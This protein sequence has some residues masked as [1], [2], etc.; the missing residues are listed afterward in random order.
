M[1]SSPEVTR[2]RRVARYLIGLAAI[3]TAV[4]TLLGLLAGVVPYLELINH[5]RWLLLAVSSLVVAAAW[6]AGGRALLRISASVLIANLVLASLPLMAQASSAARPTLRVTTFNLWI[7]N[8]EPQAV[9]GFLRETD[10]DVVVLQEI[11]NRLEQEIV[12]Q[13]RDKYPHVVSCARRNCGLVLLSKHGWL[14]AGFSDRTRLAPPIVW[15]RFAGAGR[16]YVVTGLHLAYPFQPAMQVDHID[17]LAERLRQASDTQIVVGDFNLTPFSLKLNALA[18]KANLRRHATLGA[19]WP[20]DRYVPVVLLDN[21]LAS[22]EVRAVD[23]RYG[24]GSY[25]SDHYPVTFDIAL[26]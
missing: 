16:P 10:A 6:W 5:F 2:L 8:R 1:T 24:A 18:L 15:A 23:V 3:A 4:A 19:S 11:G 9:V 13:L 20:A 22:P 12:P 17:W 21:L 25:G 26:D 14:D 7:G